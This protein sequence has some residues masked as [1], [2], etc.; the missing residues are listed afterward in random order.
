MHFGTRQ[1]PSSGDKDYLLSRVLNTKFVNCPLF[2]FYL[3]VTIFLLFI[4]LFSLITFSFFIFIFLRFC[5]FFACQGFKKYFM[6]TSNMKKKQ[7][8]FSFFQKYFFGLFFLC[9]CFFI[10]Q[11]F[12]QSQ[13]NIIVEIFIGK[14]IEKLKQ[15]KT[16]SS[17]SEATNDRLS[18]R[19]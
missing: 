9:F 2:Y 18:Y 13:K 17:E 10:C 5:L 15:L 19:N 16:E 1:S 8:F 7:F 11:I 3:T 4:H 14:K 12:A 6:R